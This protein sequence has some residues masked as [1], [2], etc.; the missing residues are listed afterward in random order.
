[1]RECILEEGVLDLHQV[2]DG[3]LH[4]LACWRVPDALKV[5]SGNILRQDVWP[6]DGVSA[7]RVPREDTRD[8]R[9]GP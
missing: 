8:L 7:S 9:R 1:M 2:V 6:L 4:G 5:V 3:M